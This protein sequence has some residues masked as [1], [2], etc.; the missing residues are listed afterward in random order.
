[1]YAEPNRERSEAHKMAEGHARNEAEVWL[2]HDTIVRAIL[3]K[4]FKWP[5]CNSLCV[6]YCSLFGV[7]NNTDMSEPVPDLA[8]EKLLLVGFDARLS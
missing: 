6:F 4:H 2:R 3:E 7:P 8:S 1:V 5:L